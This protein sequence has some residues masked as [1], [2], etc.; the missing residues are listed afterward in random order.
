MLPFG[1]RVKRLLFDQYKD[2]YIVS[3]ESTPESS[4]ISSKHTSPSQTWERNEQNDTVA[5]AQRPHS[6]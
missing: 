5:G 6:R 3:P 4:P 2:L 1:V